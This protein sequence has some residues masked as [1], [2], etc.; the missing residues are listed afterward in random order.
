MVGSRARSGGRSSIQSTPRQ[1]RWVGGQSTHPGAS[2]V[3]ARM[4]GCTR[5]GKGPR[6]CA[7]SNYESFESV[8]INSL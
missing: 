1:R 4:V 2:A 6:A 5:K 8:G 3:D 7:V